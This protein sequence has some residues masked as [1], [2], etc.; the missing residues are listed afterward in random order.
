MTSRGGGCLV[1]GR[2]G[3]S[4]KVAQ[5]KGGVRACEVEIVRLLHVE[6]HAHRVV[7]R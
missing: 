1:F 3:Q 7:R 2:V 5:R 4:L 6:A